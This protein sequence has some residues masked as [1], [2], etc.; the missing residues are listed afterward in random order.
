VTLI[1]VYELLGRRGRRRVSVAV[2][3]GLTSAPAPTRALI[4]DEARAA[5]QSA[6][7]EWRQLTEPLATTFSRSVQVE[8]RRERRAMV[9]DRHAH[10]R[11]REAKRDSD[12]A[13]P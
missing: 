10:R 6:A 9:G 2:L 4:V 12:R 3:L 8:E 11:R 13:R 5:G 1:D 7:T